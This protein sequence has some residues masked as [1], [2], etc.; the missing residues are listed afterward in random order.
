M[1]CVGVNYNEM[2][3]TWNMLHRKYTI[4]YGTLF[5][6]AEFLHLIALN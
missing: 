5:D 4:S 3:L 1:S 6:P 2:A